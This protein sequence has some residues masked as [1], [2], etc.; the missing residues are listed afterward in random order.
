MDEKSTG[1]SE[2][3]LDAVV[4]GSEGDDAQGWDPSHRFF[5]MACVK[6]NDDEE[7]D[8]AIPHLPVV[9]PTRPR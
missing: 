9:T 6:S 1:L 4:G 3:E 7:L 5:P 2:E 8:G